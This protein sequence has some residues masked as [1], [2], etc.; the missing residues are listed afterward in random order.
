MASTL[1]PTFTTTVRVINWV[2]YNTT[3]FW[4]FTKPATSTSFTKSNVNAIN[5]TYLP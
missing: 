3:N 2:L 5:V 4:F 1:R